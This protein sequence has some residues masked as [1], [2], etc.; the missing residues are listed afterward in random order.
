MRAEVSETPIHSITGQG[1]TVTYG[2]K[3]VLDG[4][5]T[6][7]TTNQLTGLIG[8]NGAGKTT[9]MRA[10]LGLA[11]IRAGQVWYGDA[12]A[13]TYN[14]RERARIA[15]YMAQGAEIHWPM[16]ARA[17]VE[18]GRMPHRHPWRSLS[19]A[20]KQCVEKAMRD[21]AITEFANRLVT[22]LSGGEKARV[23]LARTMAANTPFLFADEP[24]ASLDPHYQLEMLSLLKRQVGPERGVVVVMHDLNLAQQ[25]CDRLIV[26]SNGE[27]V[28]DGTPDE[29][30]TDQMLSRVFH[31]Q[32]SRWSEKG[33]RFM[34]PVQQGPQ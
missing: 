17:I 29:V 19:P 27:I 32:M 31:V 33:T 34:V 11:P 21:T 8:P 23:L 20:D 25:Y 24:A 14:S 7:L 4:I 3:T 10:L 13:E 18:L 6:K 2:D 15:A 30:M 28:A 22:S 5:D 26:V 12:L 16:T 9:L 1:L